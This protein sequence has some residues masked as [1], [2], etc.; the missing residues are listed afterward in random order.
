MATVT[1]KQARRITRDVLVAA[2]IRGPGFDGAACRELWK[3]WGEGERLLRRRGV[4]AHTEAVVDEMRQVCR[5]CPAEVFA[6]CSEF[7]RTEEYTGFAA[8]TTWDEGVADA[9]LPETRQRSG[10]RGEE[11]RAC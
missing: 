9:Q 7:A 6:S 2:M 4:A 5:R 10:Q 8:G 3:L 11:A 1:K